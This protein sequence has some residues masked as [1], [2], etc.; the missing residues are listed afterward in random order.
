MVT[1]EC[2]V[3]PAEGSA[4]DDSGVL[5]VLAD[6][7]PDA[8]KGTKLS[9]ICVDAE[10]N[11][12]STSTDELKKQCFPKNFS[13]IEAQL[14]V[15]P[16]V[17]SAASFSS[18][19]TATNSN[20][21]INNMYTSPE[22]DN[23]MILTKLMEKS[24][25]INSSVAERTI[26][27]HGRSTQRWLVDSASPDKVTRLVT[28]CVPI[29]SGSR[30]M[31]VS[32][33]K[34]N[35]WILPKGGWEEDEEMEESAIRETF[36]EAGVIGVLGPRL[37]EV[38]YETRKAKARRL[39]LEEKPKTKP[40]ADTQFSSGWSDVSQLSEEDHMLNDKSDSNASQNLKAEQPQSRGEP[41][42]GREDG[43]KP[44]GK[45]IAPAGEHKPNGNEAAKSTMVYSHVCVCLFPL[46]VKEIF[47]TWPESGRLRRCVSIDDAIELLAARPEMQSILR[48][49]KAR[50]LHRV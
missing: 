46:Y 17:T 8:R 31:L 14:E 2:A 3:E 25:A 19:S 50:G 38:H 12:L 26:S 42:T 36:E 11:R 43:D 47:S 13:L 27:R 44:G 29:L 37:C 32:A 22:G 18:K 16:G 10:M 1:V 34:K 48:E 21:P 4:A 9:P 49:V 39:A 45:E 35:Q 7:N 5:L 23:D 20:L 28:G 24:E 30:I 40:E 6:S 33:S 15:V 41:K